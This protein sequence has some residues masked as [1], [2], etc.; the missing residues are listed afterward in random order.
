MRALLGLTQEWF[1]AVCGI[2]EHAKAQTNKCTGNFNIK[3]SPLWSLG[4]RWKN[5][6]LNKDLKDLD[7]GLKYLDWQLKHPNS[8]LALHLAGHHSS[9]TGKELNLGVM[10]A[11][12]QCNNLSDVCSETRGTD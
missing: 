4:T 6:L 5:Q 9:Q 12:Q 8:F 10:G 3:H 2:S 11:V 1:C 7:F